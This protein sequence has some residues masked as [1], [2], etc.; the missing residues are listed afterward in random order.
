MRDAEAELEGRGGEDEQGLHE[1]AEEE[2]GAEAG[3]DDVR[4]LA[5][6]VAAGQEEAEGDGDVGRVEGLAVELRDDKGDGEEDRVA[7]LVGGEAVVIWKGDCVCG[8][9]VLVM[10][11]VVGWCKDE[12]CLPCSPVQKVKRRSSTS[13]KIDVL[14]CCRRCSLP[15]R[16]GEDSGGGVQGRG[17]SWSASW[18][19]SLG[20]PAV[21]SSSWTAMMWTGVCS[22]ARRRPC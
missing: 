1:V 15:L 10:S 13:A 18:C 22:R 19:S 12:W 4:E 2:P 6:E 9:R 7:G 5:R 14:T 21:G 17:G 8:G 20:S 3:A 16:K 11:R